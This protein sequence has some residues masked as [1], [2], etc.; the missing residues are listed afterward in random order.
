MNDDKQQISRIRQM[1]RRLVS[2]TAAVKR[3]N[4]ALDK[5]ESVQEA[6]AALDGYYGSDIWRQDFADDEAGRLPD[7]LK[8]GVLS[9]DGIWNLLT[10]VQ[11]LNRRLQET[12]N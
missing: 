10:D 1:E 2:V 9:E 6:I 12:K 4:A 7:G 3:L 5:W 8:R 11:D